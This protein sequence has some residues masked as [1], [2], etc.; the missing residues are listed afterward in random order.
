MPDQKMPV[1]WLTSITFIFG[2]CGYLR[3]RSPADNYHEPT[4]CFASE[5]YPCLI[6]EEEGQVAGFCYAQSME[7]K[8]QP[9]DIHWKLRFIFIRNIPE[10]DWEDN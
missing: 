5:G 2:K 3:H 10:K 8:R 1:Q 6:C 9:T 7:R 4:H